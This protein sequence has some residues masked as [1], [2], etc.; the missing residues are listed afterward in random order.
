[1]FHCFSR[2]PGLSAASAIAGRLGGGSRGCAH[3]L[4]ER[5]EQNLDRIIR[6]CYARELRS[7]EEKAR[8][9]PASPPEERSEDKARRPVV[10]LLNIGKPVVR[11]RGRTMC[12]P[13]YLRGGPAQQQQGTAASSGGSGSAERQAA[14]PRRWAAVEADGSGGQIRGVG[15][16]GEGGGGT[17]SILLDMR[18]GPSGIVNIKTTLSH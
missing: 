3:G 6:R 4:T 1:M 16:S 8:Q 7:L 11:G 2:E 15:L 14:S 12:G 17:S 13:A 9:Q 18:S 10:E 5:D